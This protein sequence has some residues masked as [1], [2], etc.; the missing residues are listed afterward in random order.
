MTLPTSIWKRWRKHHRG[1]RP[2][3]RDWGT[4]SN[5]CRSGNKRRSGV[6]KTGRGSSGSRH[7]SRRRP[8]M[9]IYQGQAGSPT[10]PSND[11]GG[12]SR[13]WSTIHHSHAAVAA[14]AAAAHDH[15]HQQ[16]EAWAADG[17]SQSW[18]I[19]CL[20]QDEDRARVS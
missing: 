3:R 18:R 19:S 4:W 16:G 5:A 20:L 11:S 14:V 2:S 9:S 10:G 1:K 17:A 15:H 13:H 8:T 12:K 6:S 7:K